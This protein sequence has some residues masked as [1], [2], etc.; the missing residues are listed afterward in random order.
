MKI[1]LLLISALF[2]L[3][4]S[5]FAFEVYFNSPPDGE[6]MEKSIIDL[7]NSARHSIHL[8]IYS[9]NDQ[10]IEEA[11]KEK[12]ADGVDVRIV[13]EGDNYSKRIKDLSSLDIVADP[14]DNGLMHSKYMIV[15][16]RYVYFGSANFTSSSFFKDFNNILIFD[17]EK[18]ARAFEI[19][20][21]RMRAGFFES[22]K[23]NEATSVIAEGIKIQLA[24]SP[25]SRPFNL[26]IENLKSAKFEV[27]AA[28]YAFSDAR[29]ALTLM[30]LDKKGVKVRIIA[31]DEWNSSIYSF[32]PKMEEFKFF[33]K[34][35]NIEGLFHNKYFIIDPNTYNAKVITGSYNFTL[36]AEQENSESLAVI[37]S[38]E[39]AQ[40]YL[41]NFEELWEKTAP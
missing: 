36:S 12:S 10:K 37:H 25:S 5:I 28:I 33:R 35:K 11:L 3:S 7:I 38:K 15:D 16:E 26:I 32:V 23:N 20:F 6:Q 19:D 40:L 18:F 13:M 2:I 34:F 30:A 39:I 1:F 9:I 17:S 8:S 21:E 14:L 31:D 4:S 41:K 22:S 27:D 29:I 24:F